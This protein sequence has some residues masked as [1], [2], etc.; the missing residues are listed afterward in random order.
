MPLQPRGRRPPCR[1]VG[2]SRKLPFY[3]LEEFPPGRPSLSN[4]QALCAVGRKKHSYGPWNLPQT[5]FSH[6]SRQGEALN[7]LELQFT[8]CCQLAE[9]QKLPC[10]SNEVSDPLSPWLHL[11]LGATPATLCKGLVS[12]GLPPNSPG[13]SWPGVRSNWKLC[14]WP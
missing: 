1:E 10:A 12:T 6:L 9:D 8:R 5:S 11:C 7:Q 2:C 14:S 4:L 3:K 13:P